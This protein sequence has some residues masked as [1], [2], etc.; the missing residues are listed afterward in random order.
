MPGIANNNNSS[1]NTANNANSLPPIQTTRSVPTIVTTHS[2][3]TSQ[4]VSTSYFM[5][6]PLYAAPS[7]QPNTPSSPATSSPLS[8]PG[9]SPSPISPPSAGAMAAMQNKRPSMTM[10]QFLSPDKTASGM[11]YDQMGNMYGSFMITSPQKSQVSPGGYGGGKRGGSMVL[12][13]NF[14]RP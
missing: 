4:H 10:G 1:Y 12:G 14:C 6:M 3:S 7:P 13:E 9:L 11:Y 5:N 2:P 8:L